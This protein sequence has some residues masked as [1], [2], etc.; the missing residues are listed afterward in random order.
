MIIC[1]ILSKEID[2]NN[3]IL[4]SDKKEDYLNIILSKFKIIKDI[5]NKNKTTLLNPNL[6]LY[7]LKTFLEQL[8]YSLL[9][10][11]FDQYDVFIKENDNLITNVNNQ[12][13]IDLYN[14]IFL[15]LKSDVNIF[16]NFEILYINLL[17]DSPLSKAD[18]RKLYKNVLIAIVRLYKRLDEIIN[19]ND[20][21][22]EHFDYIQEFHKYT[23]YII[24]ILFIIKDIPISKSS[25]KIENIINRS[26]LKHK[27][28]NIPA[29]INFLRY[30]LYNSKSLTVSSLSKITK[31]LNHYFTHN[32]LDIANEYERFT[33]MLILVYIVLILVEST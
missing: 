5:L 15:H 18:I 21:Y 33:L 29:I 10:N 7:T 9:L 13:V 20:T 2:E 8:E 23:I 19:S 31:F 30:R 25:I 24:M 12:L 26:I 17:V 1:D 3:D 22:D 11:I 14:D 32:D 4:I 27:G 28:L 16:I 6:N